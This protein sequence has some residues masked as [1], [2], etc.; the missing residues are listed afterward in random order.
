MSGFDINTVTI[1]GNLTRDPE[2]RSTGSGT[3]VA[4][5]RIAANNRR[6]QGNDWIDEPMFFDITVWSGL[7]EYIAK[8]VG[9]GDRVVVA[10]RLMWRE[11]ED[12][13]KNKRQAVSITADSV[14]PC[15]R[16]NGNGNGNGNSGSQEAASAPAEEPAPF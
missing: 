6:K 9:K 7:G 8:N 12:K 2:L 3:S 1:S 15:P 5:L 4:N 11:Y 14:I 10:G 16:T 13:D